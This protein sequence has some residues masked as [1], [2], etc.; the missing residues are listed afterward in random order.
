MILNYNIH[1]NI[2]AHIIEHPLHGT[3]TPNITSIC[4]CAIWSQKY[5]LNEIKCLLSFGCPNMCL[6]GQHSLHFPLV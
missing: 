3:A 4:L 6:L 2:K 1:A 5:T